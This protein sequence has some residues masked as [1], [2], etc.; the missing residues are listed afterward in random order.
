V[1]VFGFFSMRSRRPPA[2]NKLLSARRAGHPRGGDFL[3][4]LY[5]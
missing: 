2:S 5:N 3:L 1:V 4:F